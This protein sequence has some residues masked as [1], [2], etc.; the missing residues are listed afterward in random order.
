M[1]RVVP[2]AADEPAADVRRLRFE[3][4]TMMNPADFGIISG[5]NKDAGA[6]LSAPSGVALRRWRSGMLEHNSTL[7]ERFWRYVERSDH[8]CWAWLGMKNSKGYGRIRVGGKGSQIRLAH[9]VSYELHFGAIP[10]ALCVLHRCDNPA[11]VRPD[12]LFIGTPL[13]N[14]RDMVN[15]GRGYIVHHAG[16]A[17]ARRK[18]PECWPVGSNH[19]SAKL[20]EVQ[21][22]E[23]LAL[24]G[25]RSDRKV[26]AQFGV[27][28]NAIRMIWSGKSWKHVPRV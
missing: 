12:H 27:T 25:V 14:S 21:I 11:C 26:A 4:K 20:T 17:H 19:Q 7:P 18:H 2:R 9:R 5:T 8:G 15:K 3:A 16:D 1:R 22:P 6:V 13:D 24:K 10:D 28:R 23:I